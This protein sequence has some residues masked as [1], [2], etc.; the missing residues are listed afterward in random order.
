MGNTPSSGGGKSSGVS[1]GDGGKNNY[2]STYLNSSNLPLVTIKPETKN[3]SGYSEW[4]NSTSNGGYSVGSS[5]SPQDQHIQSIKEA[6]GNTGLMGAFNDKR[7][8]RDSDDGINYQVKSITASLNYY[9]VQN[10][11]AIILSDCAL[12]DKDIQVLVSG[13]QSYKLNLTLLDL[14]TNKLGYSS[15]ESIFYALRADGSY[16][17]NIQ[18]LNLFKN[19]LDDNSAN[20]IATSLEYGRFPSLKY[21][22]VSGNKIGTT[23]RGYLVQALNNISQDLSIAY[24]TIKG[25]TKEKLKV[26]ISFILHLNKENGVSSNEMFTTEQSLEHCKKAVENVSINITFGV[27]KCKKTP[28]KYL[29][30]KDLTLQD[31][32]IDILSQNK[33]LKP[34][35]SFVCIAKE[36]LFSVVDEDFSQCLTGLDSML[37]D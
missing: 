4:N 7:K 25:F 8:E 6:L 23:G 21:L 32:A 19:L 17:T 12:E 9:G 28:L 29:M 5:L 35:L 36:S 16:P 31:A 24:N 26:A 30:P 34:I 15:V 20:Y 18:S 13:I 22:D 14:S 10:L 27:A 33:N 2:N 3:S 37:D 11:K 1:S